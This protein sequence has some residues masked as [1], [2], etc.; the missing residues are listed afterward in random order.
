MIRP[1]P[2]AGEPLADYLTR[3]E[4]EPTTWRLFACLALPWLSPALVLVLDLL[5]GAPPP[6]PWPGLPI[7]TAVFTA[8]GVAGRQP[9]VAGRVAAGGPQPSPPGR[10]LVSTRILRAL[11][12][13]LVGAIALIAFAVSFEA[14]SAYAVTVGA[15]PHSLRWCAPLLVDAFTVAACLVI[16]ARSRD[17]DRAT[18]AWSLVV[19][20]SS[21]SVALNVAHA[22]AQLAARLV[23]ALPPA[24][25]LAALEL[26]MSEARRL[27][28]VQESAEPVM[29]P[30]Q[31]PKLEAAAERTSRQI[32]RELLTAEPQADVGQVMGRTGVGRRRAYE[33]L[34][35]V[36]AEANGSATG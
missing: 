16:L 8:A 14:I 2:A 33:L 29:R 32:V 11:T 18:Y 34:A 26:V 27:R 15:F 4:A 19:A 9:A 25:L 7:A 28:L 35:Q 17:G 5:P 12:W 10:P 20:A 36:R 1:H 30:A 3:L 23:A 24:A 31:P 21:A 13:L 22:P 6:L